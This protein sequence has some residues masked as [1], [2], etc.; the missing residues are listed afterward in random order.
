MPGVRYLVVADSPKIVQAAYEALKREQDY[1]ARQGYSGKLGPAVFLAI[2]GGGDNG[3][4][5][6][7]LL[8]AWTE[9]GTRPE[10]KLVTG[11]STGALIAPFAFVGKKYDATL[12]EVYTTTS[13]GDVMIKRSLLGGVLS[14]AMADNRPL[15][16]LTRKFVTQEFLEEIAA[17]HAKG[18]MLLIGT[19]DL[20]TGRGVIWDM[21][22]IATYGGPAAL[23]LF[24]K[25]MVASTS[26]PGA[27]PPMMIDVQAGGRRY[28]EM[29]VDGG[30]VAQVFAYP[31]TLRLAE[32]ATLRGANRERELYIIRNAR[33]DADW[34]EVQRATMSIAARAVASMIQSQ[35][36]GDLYRI[37][38]TAHRDGVQFNLAFIP[39]SFRAPHREEFDTEYMRSLYDTAYDMALKGF[40]WTH[41]PP[42]F[43]LPTADSPVK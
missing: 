32:E 39:S 16:A 5:A 27:F 34:I 11:I 43:A 18:R 35:G 8:N 26:I 42:G 41:A 17:E 22:K 33:L 6:A 24:V 9:T 7:G 2:S 14:D 3:A 10:F 40:P 31:V 21:G 4:F 15:L 36:I 37:Y 19:T 38:T 20:D 30:V 1:L 25:V 12:K 23:D 28:Q 13:P 29:H